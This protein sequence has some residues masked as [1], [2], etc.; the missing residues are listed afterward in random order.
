MTRWM[1]SWQVG[2]YCY[3]QVSNMICLRRVRVCQKFFLSI[4]QLENYFWTLNPMS[5]EI[6]VLRSSQMATGQI[7]D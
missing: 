2:L 3:E 6:L 5:L 4:T 7:Q 1:T